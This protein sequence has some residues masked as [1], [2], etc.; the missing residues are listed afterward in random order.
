MKKSMK[1]LR[2]MLAIAVLSS[3]MVAGAQCISV[4]LTTSDYNGSQISCAGLSDGYIKL[5]A[6][7]GSGGIQYNW[8]NGMTGAQVYGLQR[9]MAIV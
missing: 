3:P 9:G 1:F 5:S 7:G 6:Q 2:K 8:S 4:N